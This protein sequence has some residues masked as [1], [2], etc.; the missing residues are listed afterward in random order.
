MIINVFGIGIDIWFIVFIL[1]V[2]FAIYIGVRIVRS[3]GKIVWTARE[4]DEILESIEE[5]E[6]DDEWFYH[7]PANSHLGGNSYYGIDDN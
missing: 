1:F 3:E 6:K 4:N 7:N 5:Q 2:A